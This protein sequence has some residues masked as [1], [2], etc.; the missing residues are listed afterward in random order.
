MNFST[1]TFTIH[2]I[3]GH[4]STIYL[5]VY[6]DKILVLDCG[7]KCDVPK[8]ESYITKK[9]NRTLS[10]V[11]LV[12]ASHT[13]PDHAGGS[14]HLSKRNSLPLAAPKY[15]NS[16]YNGFS[17]KIQHTIDTLL[18]YHVARVNGRPF[19]NIFYNRKIRYDHPL[20]DGDR[21]PGFEDWTVI[22]APGH[23]SHDMI[24]Y[25]ET[26]KVLYAA[27]V[28]LCV[29]GKFLLPFPVPLNDYMLETLETISELDVRTLMLAHG[30][31]ITVNNGMK[32]I[33]DT[34]K[35]LLR[36]GLPPALR[37]LKYLE[38]FSPE[39]KRARI[40]KKAA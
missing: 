9:L 3:D 21:L 35:D 18:G 38:Y 33:T 24:F 10:T 5:V 4:I 34:L 30:G 1:E 26:E 16:W 29:N 19:S 31:I 20:C 17:G 13:H 14:P 39:I 7:C 6:P 11:R 40:R 32:T 12:V 25:N 15:I 28:I 23:T 8:I 37:K 27:D 22:D 36:K 2:K